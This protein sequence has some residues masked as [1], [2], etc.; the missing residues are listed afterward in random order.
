MKITKEN[1][2]KKI[3]AILSKSYPAERINLDTFLDFGDNNC[4]YMSSIEIVDFIVELEEAFDIIVD[5]NDRYYTVRDV[6]NG[7]ISYLHE[8]DCVNAEET[9]ES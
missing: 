2:F 4:L 8:K 5:Y 7:V 9:S 6:V 3:R 1:V